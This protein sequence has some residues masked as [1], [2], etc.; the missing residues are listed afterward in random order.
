MRSVTEEGV[1]HVM[2]VFMRHYAIGRG[3]LPRSQK[4]AGN[5]TSNID[6]LVKVACDEEM[7]GS[8]D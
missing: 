7:L 3:Q 4:K 2:R 1:E 8:R 6:R 5:L